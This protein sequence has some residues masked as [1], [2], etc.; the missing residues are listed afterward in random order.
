[1]P[2]FVVN[3]HLG[4]FVVVQLLPDVRLVLR[5]EPGPRL[6]RAPVI[7]VTRGHLDIVVELDNLSSFEF[8]YAG[9]EA[10]L[11]EQ[12]PLLLLLLLLS[13]LVTRLFKNVPL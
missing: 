7:L 13:L 12:V 2:T 1:M 10:E 9:P 8:V 5:R 3:I 6:V 4:G 11:P